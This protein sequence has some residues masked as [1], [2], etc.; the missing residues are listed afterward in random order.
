[1]KSKHV[2]GIILLIVFLT[3][4]SDIVLAEDLLRV[5][6]VTADPGEKKSGYIVIPA[7]SDGPE[8][9]IPITIINGT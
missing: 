3:S 2:I 7:G 4:M 6:E 5:G 8:I 9:R 1:M